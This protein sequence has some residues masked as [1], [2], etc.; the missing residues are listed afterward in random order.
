MVG[1]LRVHDELGVDG[2]E[3]LG[4]LVRAQRRELGHTGVREE[5]LEAVHPGGVQRGQGGGV[6]GDR[7]APEADVDVDLPGGGFLLD[8][9]GVHGDG[10]REAVERHVHDGG[11]PAG[12]SGPGGGGEALPLGAAG[13][14]DMHVGVHKAWQEDL[15]VGEIGDELGLST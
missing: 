9:E 12:G 3:G 10:R 7:A 11:D 5:G 8:H 2:G 13:L 6:A 14:V 15:V 1:V 4:E